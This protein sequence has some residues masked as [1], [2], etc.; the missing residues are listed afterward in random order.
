MLLLW[1]EQVC[2]IFSRKNNL[3]YS[4][5]PQVTMWKKTFPSNFYRHMNHSENNEGDGIISIILSFC[6]NSIGVETPR[7]HHV[8][9][10]PRAPRSSIPRQAKKFLSFLSSPDIIK[11]KGNCYKSLANWS[12]FLIKIIL[13][14]SYRELQEVNCSDCFTN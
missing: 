11:S 6:K 7:F 2:E 4:L 10:A 14:S 1:T 9:R 13:G 8:F 5:N 3:C 12:R